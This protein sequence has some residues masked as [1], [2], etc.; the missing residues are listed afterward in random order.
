MVD[1]Q[2]RSEYNNTLEFHQQY[3]GQAYADRFVLNCTNFK[4]GGH[5]LE[6]GSRHHKTNNNSYI[7]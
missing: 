1:S 7:L 2:K 4:R 5:F 6:L 3:N